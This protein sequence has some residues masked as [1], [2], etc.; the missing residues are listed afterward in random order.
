[1]RV[2]DG[3]S[4]LKYGLFQSPIGP[5]YIGNPMTSHFGEDYID[6]GGWRIVSI[7][8]QGNAFLNRLHLV[9]MQGGA[10][11][12]N[13]SGASGDVQLARAWRGKG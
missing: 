12:V 8:Q 4:L 10:D 2:E 6:L 5:P 7:D 9:S 1:M 3:F 13:S 11:T